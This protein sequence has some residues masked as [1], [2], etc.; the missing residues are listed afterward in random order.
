[1]PARRLEP[2]L[3]AVGV[4]LVVVLPSLVQDP[5]RTGGAA[6]GLACVVAAG[7]LLTVWRRHPVLTA[8]GGGALIIAASLL[9]GDVPDL[10]LLVLT[11]LAFVAGERFGGGAAWTSGAGFVAWLAALYLITG[12]QDGGLAMFTVPGFVAGTAL[13]LRRETADELALRG[14]ELEAERELFAQLAVRNE[15]SRIAAEL[16]DIIGH[17]LSVMVVQAAAGQRLLL[18]DSAAAQQAGADVLGVVAESAR[19]GRGDL[20]RLV[21]LLGGQAV[22]GPDLALVDEVVALAAGSGLQVTCRFEGDRDGVSTDV[23]GTAFRVVRESLTNALRHA[24]GA[25]VRVLVR[26]AT[27]V[28]EV[29]V[30]NDAP[31]SLTAGIVGTGHGLHGLRELVERGGGRFAAGATATGGWVVEAQLPAQG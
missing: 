2:W 29:R 19:Q 15:R 17:S 30:E 16:H 11:A 24:P 20:A 28:L 18:Q 5:P 12:E 26:G 21:D 27:R 10:A 13:R 23:A 25:A 14:Q 6:L 7:L 4:V 31:V 3:I 1:M 9:P 8:A 22:A